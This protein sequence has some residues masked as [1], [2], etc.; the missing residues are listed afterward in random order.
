MKTGRLFLAVVFF[1]GAIF[2]SFAQVDTKPQEEKVSAD[3]VEVYYF[4]YERR[5]ATCI[6]VEEE[7]EKALNEL[8]PGQMKSGEMTFLSV[9]LEEESNEPLAERL[10]AD[11]QTLLIVKGDKREDLTNNAFMNA[12]T[13]PDKLKKA[14][15]KAIDKL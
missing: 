13:N 6:A 9:N 8:F 12:R 4:H 5:C 2:T 1:F 10:K 3:K 14:I 11:G 15:K 7:T